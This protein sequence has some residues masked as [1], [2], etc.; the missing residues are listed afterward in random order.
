MMYSNDGTYYY[1]TATSTKTSATT[2]PSVEPSIYAFDPGLTTT[3]VS[4]LFEIEGAKYTRL[5][6]WGEDVSTD[7]NDGVKAYIEAVKLENWVR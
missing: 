2:T 3:T 7:P 4:Y 6:F 1:D 5:I